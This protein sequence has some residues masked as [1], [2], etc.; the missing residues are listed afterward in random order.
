MFDNFNSWHWVVVNLILCTFYIILV[1]KNK[2][3]VLI[4][5]DK[6]KVRLKKKRLIL[7]VS[8]VF[9]VIISLFIPQNIWR[10]GWDFYKSK[11]RSTIGDQIID[12]LDVRRVSSETIEVENLEAG[13]L[14]LCILYPIFLFKIFLTRIQGRLDGSLTSQLFQHIAS[15][16]NRVELVCF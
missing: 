15:F 12:K 3:I 14:L 8:Y 10:N 6:I 13:L 16:F 1:F 4:S 7:L 5:K 9:S 2:Q 11:H